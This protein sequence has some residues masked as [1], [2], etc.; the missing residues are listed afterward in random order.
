ML[1]YR[2]IAYYVTLVCLRQWTAGGQ[3]GQRGNHVKV[4]LTSVNVGQGRVSDHIRSTAVHS[5]LVLA[6]KL[7]AVG[8]HHVRAAIVSLTCICSKS[9]RRVSS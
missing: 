8:L 9:I 6:L 5:V 7:A 2:P 3:T 1:C 4:T